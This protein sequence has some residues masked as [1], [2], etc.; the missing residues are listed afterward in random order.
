M[1]AF[2][3]KTGKTRVGSVLGKVGGFFSG[4]FKKKDTGATATPTVTA[5][6]A[7]Q[8]ISGNSQVSGSFWG[9]LATVLGTAGLAF[10]GTKVPSSNDPNVSVAEQQQIETQNQQDAKDTGSGIFVIS[11]VVILAVIAFFYIK[12]RK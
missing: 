12:S 2:K 10:L 8:P 4:I 3:N 1:G 5:K 6:G 9:E 7:T 11:G